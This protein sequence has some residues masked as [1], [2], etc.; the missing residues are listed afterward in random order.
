MVTDDSK[1]ESMEVDDAKEEEDAARKPSVKGQLS[2]RMQ[3]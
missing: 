2:Q 1:D 3:V